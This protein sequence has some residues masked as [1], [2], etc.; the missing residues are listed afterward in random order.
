MEGD[1]SKRAY[2]EYDWGA[3]MKITKLPEISKLPELS[4]LPRV[5]KHLLET[6]SARPEF[7]SFG[8][9]MAEYVSIVLGFVLVLCLVYSV[10]YDAT[11]MKFERELS[12]NS[13]KLLQITKDSK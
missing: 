6:S 13:I 12:N 8:K 5:D 11:E 10:D 7:K 4:N 9:F 2:S 1:Y 3:V